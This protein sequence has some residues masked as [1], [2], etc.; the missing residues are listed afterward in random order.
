MSSSKTPTVSSA[1]PNLADPQTPGEAVARQMLSPAL[2]HGFLVNEIAQPELQARR[3]LRP[4]EPQPDAADVTFAAVHA[5]AP[6]AAGDTK[7]MALLLA[8]QAVSLDNMFT[9]L[10]RLA[11]ANLDRNL[12]AAE[13]LLRL[14]LKAAAGSR[15]TIE[16]LANL[17][18]PAESRGP[19]VHVSGGGQAIVAKEFHQHAKGT[20]NGKSAKQPRATG[21]GASSPV[22]RANAIEHALPG[23]SLSGEGSVPD[24]RRQRQRRPKGQ[25]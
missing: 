18:R 22:R 25:S 13:R 1:K 20:E 23:E 7:S 24:A 9:D 8:A 12:D 17:H 6:L 16:A 11:A 4:E 15:A 21:A 5:F 19:S 10:G 14:A 2:R 3:R